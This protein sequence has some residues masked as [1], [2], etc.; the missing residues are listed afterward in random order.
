MAIL[1]LGS[2]A[3]SMPSS[4]SPRSPVDS[5]ELDRWRPLHMVLVVSRRCRADEPGES[6]EVTNPFGRTEA[7]VWS[8]DVLGNMRRQGGSDLRLS[9]DEACRR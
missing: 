5:A 8:V 1:A 6:R 3:C 2:T 7:Y 4:S 9:G